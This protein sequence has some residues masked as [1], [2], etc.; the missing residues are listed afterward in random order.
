MFYKSSIKSFIHPSFHSSRQ[1][2]SLRASYVPGAI[3]G[4]RM[5]AINETD[6]VP[7]LKGKIVIARVTVNVM[8]FLEGVGQ[9]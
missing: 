9:M 7:V 4:T 2:Y 5:T 1:Q 8:S 6:K 3:L